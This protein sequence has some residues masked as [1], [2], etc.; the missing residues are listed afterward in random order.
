MNILTNELNLRYDE[1]QKKLAIC[2]P[3]QA[4]FPTPLIEITL[5]TIE[6][7][8]FSEASQFLGER[9]ILLIPDLRKQFSKY[10]K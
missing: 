9:L 5:T 1:V 3:D 2:H 6:N 10:F 4:T 8:T 7:M